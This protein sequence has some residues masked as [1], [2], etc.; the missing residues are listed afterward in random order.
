M[1]K[2]IFHLVLALFI[3]A[4]FIFSGLSKVLFVEPFEL[5]FV[6]LGF[7]WYASPFLAR[8]LIA[9]EFAL[10]LGLIF[11]VKT[12]LVLQFIIGM[13]VFFT[14]Y[15]IYLMIKSDNSADCGC[16]GEYLKM[17]PLESVIKNIVLIIPSIY[18]LF[19][20]DNFKWKF[21][22]W[23]TILI[24]IA[25]LSSA[26]GIYYFDASKFQVTNIDSRNYK[27]DVKILGDFVY[28]NNTI[29]LD[30]GKKV[31]CFFSLTC[32][33]CKLASK[34]LTIIRENLGIE[35]P[36]YYILGGSSEFLPDWWKETGSYKFP[37][38][39]IQPG[40]DRQFFSLSGGSLPSIYF[41]NDGVVWKKVNYERLHQ[42]DFEEFLEFK[43]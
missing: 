2:K 15:L 40:M 26:F 33:H 22:M 17:N 28:N 11:R 4:T 8:F 31:V 35:I 5:S 21:E 29:K 27:L 37:A 6:E 20:I 1:A 34:K 25:S 3:G 14:F 12:K 38:L 10:G 32:P 41:L 36:V 42:A 39:N 13:L 23:F 7:G 16:F 30:E 19:K 43:K 9:A 18:L 24:I